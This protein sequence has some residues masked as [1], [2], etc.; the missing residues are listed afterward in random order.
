MAAVNAA[1][2]LRYLHA[3]PHQNNTDDILTV[4]QACLPPSLR[5]SLLS[6]LQHALKLT[7]NYATEAQYEKLFRQSSLQ[8]YL[9]VQHSMS[10][11]FRLTSRTFLMMLNMGGKAGG[12]AT[13]DFTRPGKRRPSLARR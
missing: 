7:V 12:E 5:P 2:A 11:Q 4:V 3:V 8:Q 10:L 6:E 9:S 1:L 13:N